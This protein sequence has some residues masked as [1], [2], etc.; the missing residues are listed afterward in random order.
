MCLFVQDDWAS[1]P[2]FRVFALSLL[3]IF[4]GYRAPAADS[5]LHSPDAPKAPKITLCTFFAEILPGLR[6]AAVD[7]ERETGVLVEVQGTPYASFLTWLQTRFLARNPPEVLLIEGTGAP[8][9]YGQ[10]GMLVSFDRE[11]GRPN[12]FT[13]EA[14][15]WAD[16][17]REPHLQIARDVA[18]HLWLIP[19]TQY[20]TGLFRNKTIATELDLKACTTWADLSE[21]FAR[22]RDSGRYDSFV[23]AIK[24]NDAQSVW[25]ADI[26][27]ENLS[28]HLIPKVNLIHAPGWKFDPFDRHCTLNEKID[29][30]ERIVAFERG[31]IDPVRSPEYAETARLVHDLSKTWRPDF[32]SLDGEQAYRTFSKGRTAYTMNG[33]W[34]LRDFKGEMDVLREIAPERVF[35]YEVFGFPELTEASTSLTLAGGTNQNAGLRACLV[36]TKQ[37]GAW[38]GEAAMLLCEYLT[39]PRV[40]EKVL[41]HSDVYDISALKAVA[42]K[43]GTEA[44][45][46]R[47]EYAFLPVASFG[48][49]D[50]QSV[51]EFWTAWQQFLGGRIDQAG[52]LAQLSRSYREALVRLAAINP[53]EVDHGFIV[54]ELGREAFGR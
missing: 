29:L 11:I 19:F 15:A 32:L 53:R 46:P 45:L 42:P 9:Q 23:V 12:P 24:P 38:R 16:S 43:P 17:F 36:A 8:W 44:L 41:N 20:G 1:I 35:D 54:R 2:T 22:V 39:L 50:A 34:F 47:A 25:M 21:S 6:A 5:G 52:F 27:M 49:Y 3:C 31:F 18:G 14:G 13:P 30:S 40:S 51:S 37:Q 33:T 26:L 10:A 28:R 7:F 48:G 4:L